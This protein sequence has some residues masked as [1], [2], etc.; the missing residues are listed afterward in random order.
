MSSCLAEKLI[1]LSQVNFIVADDW[2][3][4]VG[5]DVIQKIYLSEF[6]DHPSGL[7]NKSRLKKER[8]L[9]ALNKVSI[10]P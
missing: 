2:Q 1:T 7:S 3:Y 9:A 5:N 4:L 6:V 8:E 10:N